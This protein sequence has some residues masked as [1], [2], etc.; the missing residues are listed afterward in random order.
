MKKLILL[1]CLALVLAAC[2]PSAE[3]QATMIATAITATAASWT[4]TPTVTNTPTTTPT[5]TPTPTDTPTPTLTPTVT[6][7]PTPTL[8]PNR[9]Y[10]SDGSFSIMIPKGW[11]TQ[12][13]GTG[14]LSLVKPS[15][16]T[17]MEN[18]TFTVQEVPF[19]V[20][21]Y[22]TMFPELMKGMFPDLKVI[23]TET[24]TTPSGLEYIRQEVEYSIS[25]VPVH[26]TI[27]FFGNNG[28]ILIAAYSRMAGP[29]AEDDPVVEDAIES[30]Q[31]GL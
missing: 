5:E 20:A 29:G 15:L 8:D 13:L 26:Q 11:K 6:D 2:G 9:Y 30:I 14:Y 25:D 18:I 16:S 28:S 10:A 7:T 22:S 23:S 21:A 19:S 24:F 4:L 1:V 17:A 27:Y 31:F 3:Q 12:D